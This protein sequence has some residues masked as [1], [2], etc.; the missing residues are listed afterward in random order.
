[1]VTWEE[2][3]EL[4]PTLALL[5]HE[6]RKVQDWPD[7][8]YFCMEPYWYGDHGFRH[9]LGRRIGWGRHGVEV[10]TDLHEGGSEKP[11]LMTAAELVVRTQGYDEIKERIRTAEE[12]EGKGILWTSEAYDLAYAHLFAILP[13]C[14]HDP[15]TH[16][17]AFTQAALDSGAAVIRIDELE[18]DD[19]SEED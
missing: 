18:Q 12:A 19:E 7:R 2:L 9:E 6:A 15:G 10:E 16:C 5:E 4:E 13:P 3:V 8:P 1:M 17:G 11:H 14:R